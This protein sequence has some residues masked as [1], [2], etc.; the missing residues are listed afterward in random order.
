MKRSEINAIMR[1]ASDF[2]RQSGFYLLILFSLAI[3][4]PSQLQSQ[5]FEQYIEKSAVPPEI[6]D[7]WLRGPSWV[8]FDAELGYILGNSLM[9]WGID[10]SA[11][12]ETVQSNGARTTI[13]YADRKARINTYGDSYTE[14]EQVNDGETWQEYL[15]GHLGEPVRNFGV[16]GYGVYQAYRRMLR[17]EKTDHGAEYIIL[18]I[19]CDDATGSLYRY[20]RATFYQFWPEHGGVT[21]HGNFWPNLEMDLN[22]GRFV[23]REN[24]LSTRESLYHM[25]DPKW[26]VQHL[27]DDLALQLALYSYGAIQDLD[28]QKVSKLAAILQFPFDWSPES[29]TATTLGLYGQR[30]T[31]MQ[32]QAAALLNRYSQRA[33]VVVLEKARAFT[34][35]NGKKLII[36]LNGNADIEEM[37]QRGTR[38]DQELID[39][40]VQERIPY[41]DINAILFQDY[42]HSN[43]SKTEYLKPYFVKGAGHLNPMGNHF[44]AYSIKDKVVKLLEA[45]ATPLPGAW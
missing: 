1:D 41:V 10:N 36:V 27:K 23:E 30:M 45:K 19:C 37:K 20:R 28:R 29:Q 9:P 12:I 31:R 7:Q 35:A 33:A 21:F 2:I 13:M 34:R 32:A 8:T 4:Q 40:L 16:G 22:T 25:T 14:C 11:T 42:K 3:V 24:P 15:A 17:E 18:T 26:M 38:D 39:Y 6:L 43:L 44:V 5:S